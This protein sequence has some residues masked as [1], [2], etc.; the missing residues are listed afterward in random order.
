MS[1]VWQGLIGSNLAKVGD[2]VECASISEFEVISFKRAV[3]SDEWVYSLKNKANNNT[4]SGVCESEL[5]KING[6]KI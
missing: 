3:L 4:V 1:S 2:I 6:V 5:D